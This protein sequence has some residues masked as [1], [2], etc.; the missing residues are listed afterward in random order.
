MVI[1]F[2]GFFIPH[3]LLYIFALEKGFFKCS[4]LLFP[5]FFLILLMITEHRP[6]EFGY[7]TDMSAKHGRQGIRNTHRLVF[8]S[9]SWLHFLP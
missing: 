2:L 9:K 7:M 5:F 1:Y 6:E 3:S 8:F 4:W